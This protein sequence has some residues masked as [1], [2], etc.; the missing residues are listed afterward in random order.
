[1]RIG[2]DIDGTIADYNPSI[3]Q[4]RHVGKEVGD[5]LFICYTELATSGVPPKEVYAS[6]QE[7]AHQPAKL[8]PDS[9]EVMQQL[10]DEGHDVVIYTNRLI[11]MNKTELEEWLHRNDI[12][13]S[14]V[15][16]EAELPAFDYHLDDN[17]A[18]LVNLGELTKHKLLLDQP[19]NRNCVDDSADVRRVYN[20]KEFASIIAANQNN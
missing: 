3:T 12:P 18:K 6:F 7:Y 15:W 19:W 20:W 13:F 9:K 2:I 11:F 17:P 16:A 1:M 10:I 14:E 4:K 5:E 8:I